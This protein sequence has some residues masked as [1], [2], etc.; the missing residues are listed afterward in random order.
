VRRAVS[1]GEVQLYVVYFCYIGVSMLFV[2]VNILIYSI[3]IIFTIFAHFSVEFCR[4]INFYMFLLKMAAS[5]I[6]L[7]AIAAVVAGN[8]VPRITMKY[9]L[10]DTLFPLTCTV[11]KYVNAIHDYSSLLLC[12]YIGS[13]EGK[14]L[15]K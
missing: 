15:D 1:A 8:H 13:Y 4:N 9:F 2:Q 10:F 14:Y 11:Y 5:L 12:D 6:S 7:A 3:L